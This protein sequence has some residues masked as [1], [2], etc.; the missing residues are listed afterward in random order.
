M[1][2]SLYGLADKL[3]QSAAPVS[4]SFSAEACSLRQFCQLFAGLGSTNKSSTFFSSSLT[5]ALFLLHF[6]LLSS[7]PPHM[8][9]LAGAVQ[10]LFFSVQLQWIFGHSFLPCNGTVVRCPYE[11]SCPCHLQSYPVFLFLP[12]VSIN[13]FFQGGGVLLH[14][15][16]STRRYPQYPLW[17]LF[18]RCACCVLSYCHYNK[19]G[20]LISVES[21]EFRISH[22]APAI[23]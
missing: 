17:N 13:L 21:A 5:L 9:H 12:H 16:P 3:S 19:H 15:N 1:T 4:L 6:S 22:A 8:T 10:S 11:V 7:T 2:C 14:H 20:L 18:H 23:A